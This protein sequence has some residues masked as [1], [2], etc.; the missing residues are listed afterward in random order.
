MRYKSATGVRTLVAYTFGHFC[1]DFACFFVLYRAFFPGL[2]D[3]RSQ[4][5][6]ALLYNAVAFAL[7]PFAG[8]WCDRFERVPAGAIG[9]AF[10]LAGLMSGSA[11]WLALVLCALGNAAFHVAGGRDS[12]SGSRR[13]MSR[14]GVFVSTGALGIALGALAGRGDCPSLLPILLVTGAGVCAAAVELR[15]PRRA[16]YPEEGGERLASGRAFPVVL[17]LCLTA[18]LLRSYVGAAIPAEWKNVGFFG[19]IPAFCSM[20]G[21]CAGGFAAD[22]W[23]A[24][25][26]GTVSLLLA[27][28]LLAW[29]HP[30]ANALGTLFFN[31]A[32]PITLCV[33]ASL[34]PRNTGFAFGLTTLALFLGV[35]PVFFFILPA[36]QALW[37]LPALCL[38]AVA[39]LYGST[40]KRE[41]AEHHDVFSAV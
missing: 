36:R 23:G 9:C 10:V 34:F 6:G 30:A 39:C 26:V 20:L 29:P 25:R 1:V 3:A 19:L 21:K 37:A 35:A 24:R 7:Q 11:P 33:A 22:A 2:A 27:T 18:V 17:T 14:S 32:M 12:L 28:A 13:P 41:A 16:S 38:C 4:M 40:T 8:W 31:M 15:E 5:S